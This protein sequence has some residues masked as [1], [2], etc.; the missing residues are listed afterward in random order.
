MHPK[1]EARSP[2]PEARSPKPDRRLA[3][4]IFLGIV[5]LS[6]SLP[7]AYSFI[8]IRQNWVLDSDFSGS[9]RISGGERDISFPQIDLNGHRMLIDAGGIGVAGTTAPH[10]Y[11]GTITSSESFLTFYFLG[12]P[13]VAGSYPSIDAVIT[14]STHKIGLRIL[15]QGNGAVFLTGDQSNTFTG[16]VEASG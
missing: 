1:P 9:L 5:V 16:N 4:V 6:L 11:G 3:K 7:C 2:K 13:H 15:N 8:E 12:S 10:L 14:D